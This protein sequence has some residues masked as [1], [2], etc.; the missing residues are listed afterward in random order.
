MTNCILTSVETG[1]K[2]YF[3]SARAASDWLGYSRTYITNAITYGRALSHKQ[4]GER[5]TI[6]Y[7]KVNIERE[8]KTSC[9]RPPVQLCTTCKNFAYGCEWSERF[10]P[11]P[12]WVAEPTII[13][14]HSSAIKSY[15]IISCPKY[16]RG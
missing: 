6:E 14:K 1:K 13:G 7:K 3:P 11:V 8:E 15:R 10:E 2:K 12:N 16:E 9:Y 5:F 4:T